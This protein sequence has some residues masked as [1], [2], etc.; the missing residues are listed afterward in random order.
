[1]Q[2]HAPLHIEEERYGNAILTH[3]PMRL[4]KAG[5]LPGLPG[6][7]DLEPRGA[8]WVAVNI[9]GCELQVMNTHLGLQQRERKRQAEALLGK[10]W[11][12]HP[13]CR[14][15]VV[16][17]G[18]F[19]AM[20]SSAV[21]KKLH[22]RLVDAQIELKS[23]RPRSTF[24][25]RFPTARIDH[26]FVDPAIRVTDIEVPSTELV[27]VASDHLPLIAEISLSPVDSW[28]GPT[29]P[30]PVADGKPGT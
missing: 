22:S 29:G 8:L 13:E 18:D 4:V 15:P 1:M 2:F 7:P 3:F 5:L 30:G 28:V 11:L 9:N 25:G 6:K 20:P 14:G 21:C 17:C 12:Q 10:Q 19:N 24:F 26:I 23:H 16:L 27:R